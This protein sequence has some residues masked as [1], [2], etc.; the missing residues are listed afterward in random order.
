[1]VDVQQLSLAENRERGRAGRATHQIE[2]ATSLNTRLW[3]DDRQAG[4]PLRGQWHLGA[5]V[6][7]EQLAVVVNHHRRTARACGN[8]CRSIRNE[9]NRMVL[10]RYAADMES[11]RIGFDCRLASG[12]DRSRERCRGFDGRLF[13]RSQTRTV[14]KAQCGRRKDYSAAV[15]AGDRRQASHEEYEPLPHGASHGRWCLS[16]GTLKGRKATSERVTC[17]SLHGGRPRPVSGR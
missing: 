16:S 2:S 7:A 13:R 11:D 9:I 17:G 6:C 15:G 14:Q 10:G 8:H 12:R 3:Q 4:I 1:M 5:S